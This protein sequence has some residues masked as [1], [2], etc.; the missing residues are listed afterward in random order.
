MPKGILDAYKRFLEGLMVY[1]TVAGG[2]GEAYHRPTSIPQ[3]D[4]LFMMVT[5]LLMRPW[6]MEMKAMPMRTRIV[7]DDLQLLSVWPRRLEQFALAFNRTPWE[8]K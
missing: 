6:I 7:A 8:P 5:A 3:G 1:N 2:V 4:P